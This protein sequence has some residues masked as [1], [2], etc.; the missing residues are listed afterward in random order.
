MRCSHTNE[1]NVNIL[2]ARVVLRS[3]RYSAV[4]SI[5]GGVA[6]DKFGLVVSVCV[7]IDIDGGLSKHRHVACFV[8][9]LVAQSVHSILVDDC[10]R[11]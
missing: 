6:H 10:G 7:K 9:D 5:H 1:A 4:N 8:A 11:D 2:E 3:N